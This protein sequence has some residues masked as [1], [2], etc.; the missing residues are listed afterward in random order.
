MIMNRNILIHHIFN[1]SLIT[2]LNFVNLFLIF[3]FLRD[4]RYMIRPY[5]FA[6]TWISFQVKRQSIEALLV[7]TPITFLIGFLSIWISQKNLK[8]K[9]QIEHSNLSSFFFCSFQS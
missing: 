9:G 4:L 1:I 6:D 5:A 3:L 8:K 2:A 7:F